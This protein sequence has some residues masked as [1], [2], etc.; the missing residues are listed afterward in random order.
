MII[1]EGTERIDK[2]RS[3]IYQTHTLMLLC[4]SNTNKHFNPNS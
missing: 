2:E 1:E 3:K 4:T